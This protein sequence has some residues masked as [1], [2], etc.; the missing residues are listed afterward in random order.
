MFLN[1]EFAF[2]TGLQVIY[3]E[4]FKGS[5]FELIDDTDPDMDE[6]RNQIIRY[7]LAIDFLK[8]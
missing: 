1:K 8:S 4:V 6:Y 2:K 5:E 7:Q 3:L